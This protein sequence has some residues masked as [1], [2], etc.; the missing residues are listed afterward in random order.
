MFQLLHRCGPGN[1]NKLIVP[2]NLPGAFL[3]S[4]IVKSGESAS[5]TEVRIT[6]VG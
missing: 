3:R 5:L 1:L 2:A 4:T 6:Y